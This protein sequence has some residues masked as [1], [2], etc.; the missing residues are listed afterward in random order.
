MA[1]PPVERII[2]GRQGMDIAREAPT[3][4]VGAMIVGSK[5]IMHKLILAGGVILGLVVET[6]QPTLAG[7][8]VDRCWTRC[9]PLLVNVSPRR[10]AKRVFHNCYVLCHGRGWLECPGG[11]LADV[12][13]GFCPSR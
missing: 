12:R 3:I 6:C 8:T 7:Q 13:L 5:L 10:E 1:Y 9:S 11:I 4:Q 2:P